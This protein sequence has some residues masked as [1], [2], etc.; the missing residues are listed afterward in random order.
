MSQ[1][2]KIRAMQARQTEFDP[3]NPRKDRKNLLYKV[4]L[5]HLHMHDGILIPPL[6]LYDIVIINNINLLL[7]LFKERQ[8]LAVFF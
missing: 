6:L 8:F 2:V 1:Q 3:Q 7:L 5:C 4:V